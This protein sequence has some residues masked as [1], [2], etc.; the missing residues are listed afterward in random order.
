MQAEM[1]LH[2]V[3]SVNPGGLADIING[4]TWLEESMTP[5]NCAA[6]REEIEL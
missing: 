5:T 3:S 2:A 4:L 6:N 1:I